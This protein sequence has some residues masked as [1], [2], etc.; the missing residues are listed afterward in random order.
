MR[1]GDDDMVLSMPEYSGSGAAAGQS[2]AGANGDSAASP[3]VWAPDVW[4]R[5]GGGAH[6][7]ERGAPAVAAHRPKDAPG[8][9][10][11]GAAPPGPACGRRGLTQRGCRNTAGLAWLGV[12]SQ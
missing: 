3:D 1:A 10:N 2:A 8:C 5:D 6:A 12:V 7:A 9:M 11:R 4:A